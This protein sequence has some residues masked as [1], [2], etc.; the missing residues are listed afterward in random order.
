MNPWKRGLLTA[1]VALAVGLVAS[2]LL[3]NG[4]ALSLPLLLVVGIILVVSLA[5]QLLR[6]R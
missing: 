6:R 2:Y 3:G 5:E 4:L 1:A